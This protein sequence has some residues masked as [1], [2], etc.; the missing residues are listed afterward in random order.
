MLVGRRLAVGG[1]SWT[2]DC[3]LGAL[4]VRICKCLQRYYVKK[5]NIQN[6]V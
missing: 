1:G 5:I 6:N 3:E 2:H 4:C